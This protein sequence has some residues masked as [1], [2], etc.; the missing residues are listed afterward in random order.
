MK[1]VILS[2]AALVFAGSVAIA[3]ERS[4]DAIEADTKEG[5]TRD[6]REGVPPV[7]DQDAAKLKARNNHSLIIQE[8]RDNQSRVNQT[9]AFSILFN[10]VG[11]IIG[12]NTSVVLQ[13]V[14]NN[15]SFVDQVGTLNYASQQQ[16]G[17]RQAPN[18]FENTA[19]ISQTGVLNRAG[20]NQ[21]GLTNSATAT[22]E[23]DLTNLS[24]VNEIYIN[25]S[26]QTQIQGEGQELA[27]NASVNQ[28]GVNHD[29]SQFQDGEGN[30]VSSTQIDDDQNSV[31]I[32]Q[33]VG[34]SA[35]SV[36]DGN[37][38]QT[39][40]DNSV[41]Q[42][43]MGDDNT[44]VA[45]QSGDNLD[46]EQSQMGNGN[47]ATATQGVMPGDQ[48]DNTGASWITQ[49]QDGESNV[50]DAFQSGRQQD[51]FQSQTGNNNLAQSS[52]EDRMNT[53]IQVQAGDDLVG[54]VN[55]SGWS[56]FASQ[57]QS[58]TLNVAI[59]TQS[60]DGNDSYQIQTGD[61][62]SSF[63]GGVN[64]S[65]VFQAGVKNVSWT[66][67]QNLA[68]GPN[69][70]NQIFVTQGGNRDFSK[71]M[72]TGSVNTAIVNQNAGGNAFQAGAVAPTSQNNA[73]ANRSQRGN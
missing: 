26:R 73:L 60:G 5:L 6:V 37:A 66:L 31:Q 69:G 67:Q 59:A 51:A 54:E 12:K 61:G 29:A 22:Q 71:V 4:H 36:Q 44:A 55:Q 52:Q 38:A 10:G 39:T 64:L 72:Q 8:G 2:A 40:G 62:D 7:F 34:N 63:N 18:T 1:K 21:T 48:S 45:N 49:V 25:E 15:R 57:E 11:P 46:I 33:G 43:Q 13:N 70:G 9:D 41:Y 16:T 17:V 53:S 50:A 58:G 20:Q 3:Q 65:D 14:G 32:Q 56:Q 24:E 30:D 68:D 23:T 27:N 42:F 19:T 28:F 35:T 47:S